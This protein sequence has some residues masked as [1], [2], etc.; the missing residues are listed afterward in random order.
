MF[1]S[2]LLTER[3]VNLQ[4][5]LVLAAPAPRPGSSVQSPDIVEDCPKTRGIG[6]AFT[7]RRVNNRSSPPRGPDVPSPD[8]LPV[9]D[10][11]GRAYDAMQVFQSL[12]EI[13]KDVSS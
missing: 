8:D 4:K 6:W 10:P 3:P 12:I 11:P 1:G 2:W 9:P 5:L 13:Q 7:R